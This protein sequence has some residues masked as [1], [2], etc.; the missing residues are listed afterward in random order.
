MEFNVLGDIP[1][2]AQI[3][4]FLG[5]RVDHLALREQAYQGVKAVK[6]L[7]DDLVM[8]KSLGDLNVPREAI[9]QMAEAAMNVTRLMGNNPRIMTIEDVKSVFD[10]AL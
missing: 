10:K 5:E 3:A 1:K 8:P 7:Y 9:P 2:F 4:E 6:A